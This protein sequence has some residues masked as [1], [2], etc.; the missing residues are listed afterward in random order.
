MSLRHVCA[1]G[2][3]T[4]AAAAPASATSSHCTPLP[5][6]RDWYAFTS[7][8][9]SGI[10]CDSARTLALHYFRHTHLDGWSCTHTLVPPRSTRFSCFNNAAH[11]QTVAG[12]WYV[13]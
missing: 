10:G 8:H 13:H 2:L 7:L 6:S 1:T 12:S 9:Q 4:L 5:S 3:V 11:H